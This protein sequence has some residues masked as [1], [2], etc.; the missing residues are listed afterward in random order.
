[1]KKTALIETIPRAEIDRILYHAM[2]AVYQFDQLKV[3]LFG[4]T[5]QDSYLLYYLRKHSPVR[6]SAIAAE[7]KVHL[8]TASRA[9][10]RLVARTL[11]SR[12]KDPA[13]KRGILVAIEPAG[14]ALMKAS[15]DHSFDKI[16]AG[17]RGYSASELAAVMKAAANLSAIL[18]VPAL[19]GG[20]LCGENNKGVGI[21]RR[22][23]QSLRRTP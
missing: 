5:Y 21:R 13:D 11:V 6:M 2:A 7:L 12:V 1:M 4:M 23:Q 22:R 20:P 15:E 3:Q 8:S 17:L 14:E 9:V 10:D 18:G 19:D 16:R